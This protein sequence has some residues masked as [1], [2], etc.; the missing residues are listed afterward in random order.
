MEHIEQAGI[1]SGDSACSLPPHTL[2]D[3]TIAELKRQTGLLADGLNVRGLMNVQFAIKGSDIFILEVNPRASRTVPFVAKAIGVPIAKIAARIMAGEKLADIPH[4]PGPIDHVAVK[5]AVFPFARFPGVDT[6][7]GP[8][9]RSTGEVMGLDRTFNRAFLKAQIGASATPPKD[10][11][12]F[13]SVKDAD[14]DAT[15]AIVRRLASCGFSILATDGT[16]RFLSERG[17]EVQRINKVMQGQPHILDRMKDG[18]VQLV[19]NTTEGAEAI[20]DSFDIRATALK[21]KTPYFTTAAGAAA[22]T[23]AI[24]NLRD[25]ALEVAPLQSYFR[26]P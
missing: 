13:V 4:E 3:A 1:H 23:A 17:V 10:G 16:A 15:V 20:R 18:G 5:E 6:L 24:D 14:K 25:G 11:T 19:I 21:L 26:L 7:L 8:E 12:A 9:M 22:A 2:D